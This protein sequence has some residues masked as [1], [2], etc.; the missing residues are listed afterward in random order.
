MSLKTGQWKLQKL[1]SNEK[2]RGMKKIKY[3]RTKK[4]FE[5]V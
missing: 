2:K 4:Q 5:K 1:K 3:P